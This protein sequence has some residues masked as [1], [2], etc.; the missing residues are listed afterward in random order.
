[1]NWKSEGGGND[2]EDMFKSWRVKG[3]D[4]RVFRTP[5]KGEENLKGASQDEP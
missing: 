2:G 4:L 5:K 1:V 3:E